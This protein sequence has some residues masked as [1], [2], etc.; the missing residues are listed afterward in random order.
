LE[1]SLQEA[2]QESIAAQ[3]QTSQIVIEM[4]SHIKSIESIKDKNLNRLKL[5]RG[6]ISQV[7]PSAAWELQAGVSKARQI[8]E[9]CEITIKKIKDEINKTS[10]LKATPVPVDG[11]ENLYNS[12]VGYTGNSAN[13]NKVYDNT[14]DLISKL[15]EKRYGI[16]TQ[17]EY[18][19]PYLGTSEY[20]SNYDLADKAKI[21]LGYTE[22]TDYFKKPIQLPSLY[23]EKNP[24]FSKH[25]I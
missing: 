1:Y 5:L 2:R 21:G 12:N 4:K 8:I 7:G 15:D 22:M 18:T 19:K 16:L 25:Y 9:Q 24:E 17:T 13:N 11:V 6:E 3:K 14:D 10:N 20:R 23:Q